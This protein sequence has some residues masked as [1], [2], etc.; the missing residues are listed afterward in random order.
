MS[1][2]QLPSLSLEYVRATIEGPPNKT[3][4]GPEMAILPEGEDPDSGD[5]ETAEWSGD[6]VIILVGPGGAFT[7]TKGVRYEV[8]VRIT[9]SPEIPV[10][11]PG[12]I[13]AT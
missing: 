2:L 5:W 13:H 12:F 4:F 7:L 1:L 10:L 3:S 11:R 6:D 8:W 9:A